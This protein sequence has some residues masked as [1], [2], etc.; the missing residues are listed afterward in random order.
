MLSDFAQQ[1]E[2][3]LTLKNR[4]FESPKNRIFFPKG[5][6]YALGEK[7]PIFSL[8]TFGQNK[9]RNIA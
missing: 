8:F 4:I 9:T 1:K 2:T 5:L 3:F 7:M 6:T